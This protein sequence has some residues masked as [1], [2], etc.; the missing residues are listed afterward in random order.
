M[1]T[2]YLRRA[3]EQLWPGHL[4][5]G[6]KNIVL[7]VNNF[8]NLHCVM[9][10]VGTGNNETNFGANLVGA[11]TKSMPMDLFRHIADEVLGFCP[12]AHLAFAFTEPL[13]WQ[14]LGEALAYCHAL[15][16]YATVTTN[17]LLLSRR[18]DEL[19]SGGCRELSVSLDGPEATHDRIR[20][21]AG[22]YALAVAGIETISAKSHGPR[23]SVYCTIT[24]WN[25][26]TLKQ[27]LGDMSRLPLK[28]V[29]LL[30]NNFVTGAQA[31][32]HNKI[33]DEIL[34]ATPSNVFESN[35]EKIALELLSS[36]LM[37]I[38]A[39]EYPFPVTIHPSLTKFDDLAVYYR[40]PEIFVGRRCN[41][42]NR[43]LMIDS[44]GEAI[45]V[46]GRCYRFPIANIRNIRLKDIW[47]HENLATLRGTLHRAGGLLPACSRCCG[48]FGGAG[49]ER[50]R[51]KAGRSHLSA[52]RSREL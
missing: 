15:G 41:D 21:R 6:P 16:L 47:N 45:P 29:G 2:N 23:I 14:P 19:V 32:T 36:E 30:H 35:P 9:C 27:F 13:A 11:K 25:V 42:V 4:A 48:G 18:A 33:Y 40:Q 38:A 17:G 44:D 10:D 24:E 5:F 22:S 50:G 49:E 37:E 43:I 26:G 8:C 46:H 7:G 34:P 20:R 51:R 1:I 31:E 28:R 39:S 12:S 52:R 3:N